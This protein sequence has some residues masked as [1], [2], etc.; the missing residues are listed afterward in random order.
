SILSVS[1]LTLTSRAGG[2]EHGWQTG[3]EGQLQMLPPRPAAHPPGTTVEVRDLFFN[4]PARRKFMKADA[5][6]FRHVQ[7]LLSRIALARFSAGFALTHNGRKVFDL[8]AADDDGAR[9]NRVG[10]ICGAEFL[11]NAIAL[12]RE[13]GGLRLQ[14]WVGVPAF[15]RSAPDLQFLYVNGRA[16]RDRLLGHA[17]R[18]AYA[19]VMHSQ[20]YPAFVLYLEMD[21]AGVDVNV[22]PQK[23]EVRF[24]E[25]NRV[26]DFVTSAVQAALRALRPQPALHQLR[27]APPEMPSPQQPMRYSIPPAAPR[28]LA[29]SAPARLEQTWAALRAPPQEQPDELPLGHAVAQLHGIY[30]LA[31]NRHGLVL[32]DAHAAHERVLYERCK[33]DLSRGAI[34]TQALLLPV[35]VPLHEDQAESLEARREELARVG[36]QIDRA[37]PATIA[38]RAVPPLLAREDIAGFVRRLVGEEDGPAHFGE[39]L[40][41][42]HRVMADMACKAAIKAHRELR[43]PEM[44]AL[45]RDMEQTELSGQCNHG[46]PTWMQLSMDELDRLFLRGR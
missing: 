40:D 26:H 13:Q 20:H 24:R 21:A 4:T 33:R 17:L 6:E 32:V 27:I 28:P 23:T 16:V 30:I 2:A 15:A 38:V 3:G 44:D 7:Q 8:R 14:G 45:L 34:A 19:D 31:Q 41:A 10:E 22:H 1:R 37:G 29:E 46:R 11:D 18:Q 35:M 5:T 12:E 9:A 25:G 36:V 43:L 42:Q 39:V